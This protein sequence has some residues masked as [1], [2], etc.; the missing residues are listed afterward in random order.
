MLELGVTNKT[1]AENCCIRAILSNVTGKWRMLL[2]LALESGP[3]RFGAIKRCLGDI[4]QR[5]LTE[6]LRSLERDGYVSRHVET[7]PPIA[8]YYELTPLGQQLV[9]RLKP[10]VFWSHS[11]MDT[12][13]SARVHYDA[14]SAR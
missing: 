10:L 5:V 3:M 2:L 14:H 13:K 9:D 1:E 7:G 6:N 11:N 8:V 4:T 12:V